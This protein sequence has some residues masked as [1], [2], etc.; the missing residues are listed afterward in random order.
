MYTGLQAVITDHR[1]ALIELSFFLPVNPYHLY[2]QGDICR[3]E[4]AYRSYHNSLFELF[5][6]QRPYLWYTACIWQSV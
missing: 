1:E 5:T 4:N 2:N 6:Y 3:C